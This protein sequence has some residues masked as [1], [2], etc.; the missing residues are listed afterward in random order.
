MNLLYVK[1]TMSNILSL[2][3]RE[4]H[5]AEVDELNGFLEDKYSQIKNTDDK[6]RDNA[7][8]IKSNETCYEVN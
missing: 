5:E 4:A 6:N 1:C 3:E 8:V 2:Q 7:K